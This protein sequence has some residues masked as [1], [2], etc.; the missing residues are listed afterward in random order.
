MMAST[1]SSLHPSPVIG[2]LIAPR[3]RRRKAFG[4]V[5]ASMAPTLLHHAFLYFR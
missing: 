4:D 2:V 5:V 1:I 3:R